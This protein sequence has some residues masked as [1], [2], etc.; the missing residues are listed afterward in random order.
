MQNNRF[1]RAS[2]RISTYT[3]KLLNSLLPIILAEFIWFAISFIL[4]ARLDP[5][6]ATSH[7]SPMIEYLMT[8]LLITLG[9]AVVFD[10]SLREQNQK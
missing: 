3:I 1:F 8:S 4:A 7:Y 9:G 5:L 2:R 6:G 10:I